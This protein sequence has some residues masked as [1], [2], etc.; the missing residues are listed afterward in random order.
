MFSLKDSGGL[1]LL[2]S[3]TQ[4]ITSCPNSISTGKSRFPIYPVEPVSSIF[5][6]IYDK[7]LAIIYKGLKY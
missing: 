1:N 2:G 3:L 7:V 6:L 5:I 4:Q